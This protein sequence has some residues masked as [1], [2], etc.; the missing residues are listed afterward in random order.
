MGKLT[1]MRNQQLEKRALIISI[2]GA[3]VMTALGLYFAFVAE[4]A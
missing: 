4:S 1:F 2:I 3:V